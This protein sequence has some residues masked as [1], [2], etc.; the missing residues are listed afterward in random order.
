MDNET[1]ISFMALHSHPIIEG[2]TALRNISKRDALEFFYTSK[3][4]KL[5][6]RED[7]KL[8]HFSN[9]TLTDMLNQEITEGHIVFPVEG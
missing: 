9:V 6:E 7:T 2:L 4:Y 3:L 5:Y 8:W 1:Y